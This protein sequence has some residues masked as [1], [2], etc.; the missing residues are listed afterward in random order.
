VPSDFATV[1][2]ALA[3]SSVGDTVLLAPG[4]YV[5]N[6]DLPSGVRIVGD[7]PRESV[8]LHGTGSGSVV[9]CLSTGPLTG[10]S[11][12]TLEAGTGTFDGGARLGGAIYMQAARLRLE[13]VVIQANQAD[14]GGGVYAHLSTLVWIDGVLAGNAASAGGGL[15]L[16][17]GSHSLTGVDATANRA[18]RGGALYALDLTLLAFDQCDW[19]QNVA[20]EQ[21]GA[22]AFVGS[23]AV[24]T[25]CRFERNSADYG[26][27]WMVGEGS[28]VECTRCVFYENRAD[29]A[30]GG[31][32]A[33]CDG[34]PGSGC[35]QALVAA[36]DFFRNRGPQAAPAGAAGAAEVRIERSALAGN[37]T[38]PACLDA[39]A[40]LALA[41][42]AVAANGPP[43][44]GACPVTESDVVILDPHLCDLDGG[45]LERCSNSPLLVAPACSGE[46]YGALGLGCGPCG[47][48]QAEVFTWGRVKGRY[49]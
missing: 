31:V 15:F 12:L 42:S 7:G 35:A 3:V 6:L 37:D 16:S 11:S 22:A 32:H 1:A 21:G 19:A 18:D 29:V 24:A 27:A 45:L 39:R 8:V 25:L 5:E 33:S 40:E 38:P 41:C 48:T 9:R 28:Q 14:V 47:P 20:L 43:P 36:S 49:R 4:T 13:N 34:L 10:L 26:G 30:G 23:A 2:A 44:G 46:P 17:G